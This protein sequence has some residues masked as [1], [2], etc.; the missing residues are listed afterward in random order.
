MQYTRL[1]STGLKVSRLCLGM[2]TYGSQQWRAWVLE[3]KESLPLIAQAWE[4]GI[5]FFDT[6]DMYSLG[7]SEEITGKALR[8]IGIPRE[9]VVV[10]TKLF[11]PMGSDVNAKGLSRKHLR[12]S[13]DA[14]LRRLG[15]DY[16][17]LYQIHRFD[18][19]T[20]IDEIMEGLDDVVR[21][22]K[23]LY[24]GASSMFAW[25]LAELQHSAARHGWTKFVSMQNHY[26]LAYREEEREMIPYCQAHGLGLLPW[27][28][29]AR[30]L[31][32]GSISREAKSSLRAQTDDF[33][34]KLYSVE[35]D[36]VVADRVAQVAAARNLPRAQV[37][38]AWLLS[39]PYVTAP[40]IGAS[41]PQHISDAVAALDLQ[42]AP[43]EIEQLESAYQPHPVLGHS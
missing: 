31:L 7:V 26:N 12:H 25:Q 28:P 11:N 24:I 17:D 38:L 6:A 37:A 27:S 32:T 35:A 1:G 14:S 33:A 10:A 20:P 15:L 13:I 29:F 8:A 2:M 5:N 4:A 40:I 23:A 9:K 30:G 21:A 19:E 22:G 34:H 42:L 41:K 16:V 36:F 18:K 43:A 3:E 39:K